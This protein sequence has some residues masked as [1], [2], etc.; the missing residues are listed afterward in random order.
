MRRRGGQHRPAPSPHPS[1]LNDRLV[2]QVIDLVRASGVLD[3]LAVLEASRPGPRGLPSETVMVGMV[4]AARELRST[5][6]DDAWECVQFRVRAPWLTYFGLPAV[7]R[8]DIEATRAS[9]KRFYDAWSRITTLLDPARHDRRTRM[10][11]EQAVTYR[12]AWLQRTH[13]DST[14]VL[15]RI[16]NKLVLTPVRTAVA[17]GLMDEWAG[18]LSVDATAIP[19]WARHSTRHRAS[20]EVSAGVHVSGGGHKTFGYSATLLVAGHAEP[21][22]AGRYPQLCMGMS[23]HT[24]GKQIGPQAVRLLQVVKR[25]WP[26]QGYLAGDLAYADA[27]VENFHDPVRAV[28]YKPV[29]DYK[30]TMVRKNKNAVEG[31]IAIAGDLLCPHTPQ[32]IIDTYH[33]M[34]AAKQSRTR[35]ELLPEMLEADPYVLPLKQSADHRGLERRQCPAAGTSPRVTCPWAQERDASGAHRRRNHTPRRPVRAQPHTI[36]LTNRRAR[37]AHPDA[38]PAVRPPQRPAHQRPAICQQSTITVPVDI[39]PKLRQELPWGR[40]AWQRAYRSLRSHVEGLNGRAKNVD[41]FLHSREK[42]QSRGRVAQTLLSAIQ[43]M[44]ENLRSIESF[45]RAQRLWKEENYTLGHIAETPDPY[46]SPDEERGAAD[47]A[48]PPEP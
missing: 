14:P 15:S 3:E 7:D 47:S 40:E 34:A 9:A 11:R 42:R 28:G 38:R 10:P 8:T 30:T 39:M 48:P 2:R 23:L 27:K 20:L 45:L 22:L 19:T 6:V 33:R 41:T 26:V 37:Q 12:R 4:L 43:L 1:L 44:V 25:M 31:T 5:N 32:R 36:D 18:D 35:E 21:S 13:H 17:R 16:A 24:P 46:E 29:L